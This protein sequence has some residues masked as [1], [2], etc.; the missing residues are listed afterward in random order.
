[1]SYPECEEIYTVTLNA[2]LTAP[3]IPGFLAFREVQHCIR[4]L[5]KLK[6]KNLNMSLKSFWWTEMEFYTIKGLD[7]R[8]ILELWPIYQR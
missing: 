7:W 4:A 8:V 3:Y 5:D 1:M 2:H 6:K